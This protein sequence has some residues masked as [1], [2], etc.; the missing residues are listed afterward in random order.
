M[1]IIEFGKALVPVYA[2]AGGG[3][4]ADSFIIRKFIDKT[5]NSKKK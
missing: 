4:T 5:G 1:I 3:D 2:Y